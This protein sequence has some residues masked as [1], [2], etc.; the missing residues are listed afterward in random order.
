MIFYTYELF[1]D[2]ELLIRAAKIIVY[3]YKIT[4]NIHI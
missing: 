3:T 4:T 1:D 2:I